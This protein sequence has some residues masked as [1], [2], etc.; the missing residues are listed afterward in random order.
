MGKMSENSKCNVVSFRLDDHHMARLL[1]CLARG[2]NRGDL[3]RELVEAGIA[4]REM[5]KAVMRGEYR[6]I[7]EGPRHDQ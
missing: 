5:E 4:Q 7:F 3:A 1:K 2:Q 6:S